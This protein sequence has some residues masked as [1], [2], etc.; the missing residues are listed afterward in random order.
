M[1]REVIDVLLVGSEGRESGFAMLPTE[2]VPD[3]PCR[4]DIELA[5]VQQAQG[6]VLD[7]QEKKL[8]QYTIYIS[9]DLLERIL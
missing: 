3:L 2:E 8:F 4:S 5:V 1:T 7:A 6:I 9:R